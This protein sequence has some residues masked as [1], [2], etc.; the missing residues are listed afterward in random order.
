MTKILTFLKNN[1]III[2]I[3]FAA[4][5]VRSYKP[6]ELFMYSHDQDLSGWIVKDVL[7]NHHIRL[8]GQETSSKG[9]FIGPI[10]YYLQIPF[11]ILTKMDPSGLLILSILFG[12]FTVFSFYF[13]FGRI[14]NKKVGLIA[15]L[16]YAI[17]TVIVFTDREAVPTVPVMLWTV[18][19]FY[20]LWKILNGKQKY[21]ILVGLLFGLVWDLSLALALLSPLVVIAHIFSKQKVEIKKVFL[22]LTVFAIL[23][24][25][26]FVFEARHGF[27]QTKSLISSFTTSKDYVPGTARGLAKTDRVLQL[28]HTNTTRIFWSSTNNVPAANTFYVLVFVFLILV[29]SRVLRKDLALLMLLWQVLFVLFFTFNSINVSEYYI[30]G[31]NLVWIGIAAIA[32]GK[33][34]ENENAKYLGFTLIAVFIGV[35]TYGFFTYHVNESGYIQ[36]KA[37][38]AY[39]D[40]DA[41][42]HNYP[43]VSV[44]YITSPG[45]NLGYRYLFWLRN[46][47][48]DLPQGGAPVY[49]IVYP[50]SGVSKLD[51][52]FG[53]LGLILPDYKKYTKM[54]IEKSCSGENQNVTGPLFG[55]TQ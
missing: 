39:I 17:S 32:L 27:Q 46:M 41:K 3:L 29:I 42:A 54:G 33:L 52:T 1:W 9:I 14:F 22:G 44:S 13:V 25:P 49:S 18:W 37:I 19:Y 12:V 7:V 4:L 20:C 23:M 11:Y 53:A 5:F 51:K 28:V 36:R 35:S 24:I 38:V 15:A 16:I 8:I 40:E 34:L 21:Y 43:C 45:N 2:L 6:L 47:H 10:F 55:Y 26:F 50:L 31:M 48:V 30:N